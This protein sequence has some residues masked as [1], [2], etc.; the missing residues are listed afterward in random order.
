VIGNHVN[1]ASRIE[2]FSLRGQILIS[3]NTY[4]HI[5]EL[6]EV[7]EC[8][9]VSM[10]GKSQAIKIYELL[11][12]NKPLNLT[13]P[14]LEARKFH[15]VNVSLLTDFQLLDEKKITPE[16]HQAEIRDISY[17]GLSLKTEIAID[18]FTELRL[19]VNLSLFGMDT[20]DVYAMV[21][22]LSMEDGEIILGL[23]FTTIDDDARTA[24][25]NYVDTLIY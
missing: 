18:K 22:R 6:V 13:L 1:I 11:G 17:G 23:E 2:A 24:I 15:R 12:I 14:D 7:G 8:N 4:D 16:V 21:V 20:R 19:R 9:E 5:K 25:K 3:H 10:K